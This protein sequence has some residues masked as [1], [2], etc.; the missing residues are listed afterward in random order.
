MLARSTANA[1]VKQMNRPC[2]VFLTSA[3]CVRIHVQVKYPVWSAFATPAGAFALSSSQT[4]ASQRS[5]TG[6]DTRAVV[7]KTSVDS[8]VI[9]T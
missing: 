9:R 7:G 2:A 5:N 6:R 8:A 1:I 4:H 3:S